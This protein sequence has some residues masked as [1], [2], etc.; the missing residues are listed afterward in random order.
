MATPGLI[1]LCRDSTLM[2]GSDR[3]DRPMSTRFDEQD[4]FVIFDEVEVPKDLVFIDCNREV[5]NTVM[6]ISW[7]PNIMQQTTVRAL[8]KLEFAYALACRMAAAVGDESD[9]TTDMLGELACYVEMTRN[10]IIAS[11]QLCR[12]YGDGIVFP[13]DRALA[14]HAQPPDGLD[15]PGP[16]DHHAHR[17]P[18]LAGHPEP[19]HARRRAVAPAHRHLSR[20]RQRR[21][22]RGPR[23]RCSGWRGTSWV[24]GSVAG[25]S[26]TSA[27]TSARAPG[28][29]R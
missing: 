25:S 24:P 5:Y 18:Q 19:R 4:A 26:S 8:T 12:D 6:A 22:R 20:H 11:E 2:P 13:D 29:A 9:I 23:V 21:R 16:R 7:W 3:F 1:F 27:S 15:P 10:A 28:T 14:P 17:Q